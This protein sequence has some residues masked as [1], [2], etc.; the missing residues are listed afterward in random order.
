MDAILGSILN[1]IVRAMQYH[2]ERKRIDSSHFTFFWLAS[3]SQPGIRFWNLQ[4]QSVWFEIANE[5]RV[6]QQ[7]IMF[8]EYL[9]VPKIRTATFLTA[10]FTKFFEI[11]I[12][13]LSYKNCYLNFCRYNTISKRFN[14]INN[15]DWSRD[16]TLQVSDSYSEHGLMPRAWIAGVTCK[17]EALAKFLKWIRNIIY[18]NKTCSLNHCGSHSILKRL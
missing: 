4:C 15:E 16:D 13:N 1:T 6:T 18:F 5:S 9:A 2:L 11:K 12:K 17:M 7:V 3:V 14:S 10:G 8:F